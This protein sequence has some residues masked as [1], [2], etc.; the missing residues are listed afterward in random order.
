MSS[1]VDKQFLVKW[2]HVFVTTL[3][4]LHIYVYQCTQCQ[5]R[6]INQF[7]LHWKNLTSI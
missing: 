7:L 4:C 5:H 6:T 1:T 3:Q 2:K